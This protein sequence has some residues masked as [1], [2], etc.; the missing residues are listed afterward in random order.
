M[1]NLRRRNARHAMRNFHGWFN[2]RCQKQG[3]LSLSLSDDGVACVQQLLPMRFWG[4]CNYPLQLCQGIEICLPIG[5]RAAQ[6]SS[7]TRADAIFSP[8]HTLKGQ[9]FE[10]ASKVVH[11]RA[12]LEIRADNQRTPQR[13]LSMVR[14]TSMSFQDSSDLGLAACLPNSC[15]IHIKTAMLRSVCACSMDLRQKVGFEMPYWM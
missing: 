13:A 12:V 11:Y 8:P 5:Q 15:D 6:S 10:P 1:Q 14:L 2:A 7:Q 3:S 4:H 9:F